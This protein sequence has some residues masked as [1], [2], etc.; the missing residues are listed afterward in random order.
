MP[1]YDYECGNCGHRQEERHPAGER[2]ALICPQCGDLLRWC[3]PTP[4]LH[5]DTTFL[6]GKQTN[7]FFSNQLNCWVSSREDVKR[8]CRKRGWGCEGAV[9]CAAAPSIVTDKPYEVADDL[10]ENEIASECAAQGVAAMRQDDFE[11]RKVA[12]KKEMAG[13]LGKKK[14]HD[15]AIPNLLRRT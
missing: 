10:V 9:E 3:F 13:S 8:E 11:N 7:G 5:T 2:L 12:L 6:K 4:A 1:A 15:K 14:K